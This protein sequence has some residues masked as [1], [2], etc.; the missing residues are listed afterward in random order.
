MGTPAENLAKFQEISNRGI[1]DRLPENIRVRFDEALRRGLITSPQQ[2]AQEPAAG[3]D[4]GILASIAEPITAVTDPAAT[5]LTGAIAEP[6]AGLAGI[7]ALLPGGRTPTE[8]IKATREALT[9]KPRTEAGKAGLEVVGEGVKSLVG[10]A[11]IP[12]SGVAGLTELATGQGLEQAAETVRNIQGKP[13]FAK[14]IGQR[15]LEETGSPAVA[16]LVETVPT[17]ILTRL[18]VKTKPG[19]V[20]DI[21]P[22]RVSEI[23]KVLASS[24]KQGIDVLTTDIFQP[25][26]IFSRLSSQFAERVPLLGTGGKRAKQ[27]TQRVEA[28]EKLEQSTPRVEAA[29][30]I[31]SL[32]QSANKIR[33]AAGGRINTVAESMDQLGTVPTRNAVAAIDSALEKISRPGKLKNDVL[34]DEL[35]N[36]KQ[37]LTEADQSFKS[38]REFRTDARAISEKV[39]PAGRS[40]LR[41]SDKALMDQVTKGL[42]K[43]LDDFVLS[44]SDPRNLSRYKKADQIYAQEAAKLTK[45]RLKTVLDKGD[46][47]PELVNNLLFSSSPSQVK[48]LFKNL[49]TQGRQNARMALLRRA[50]DKSTKA[51]EISPQRFASELDK[52]SDNFN[53]FFRGEAKAEIN[54]LKRLLVTTKRAAEAGVTTPTGQAIQIPAATAIAAGAGI[55]D[56]R[57]I[58]TLFLA[59]TVGLTA[60]AYESAGV[61]NML[62][63]LGKSPKRSTL[64]ADLKKSI[65]LLLEQASQVVTREEQATQNPSVSPAAGQ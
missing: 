6:I 13:G 38:L 4:R 20:P 5:L 45:S 63:R 36:L 28:L 52:L 35:N 21:S 53:V 12:L 62:I 58:A 14:T 22:Q 32:D 10:T 7:G 43:D 60:R 46:V 11:N 61:R 56:P 48:L 29:D 37:T 64:E 2:P 27:Q 18:G 44:N 55:G 54:G 25:Q 34:I 23:N 16:A 26:S 1:Q 41:S 39:D 9:F 40:Q 31:T 17:A 42:T 8:A 47:N 3:E 49:D 30:I 24:Q 57:A 51:G 15:T 59:S 33:R 65:P 50:L 19:G